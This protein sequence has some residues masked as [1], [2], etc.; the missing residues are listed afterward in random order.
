MGEIK[1]FDPEDITRSARYFPLVGQGVGAASAAALL[2]A[3][4]LWGG[5]WNPA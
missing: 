1:G 3:S 4:E 2:A 5:G